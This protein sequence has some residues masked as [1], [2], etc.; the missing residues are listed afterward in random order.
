MKRII[1][2][3]T[4]VATAMITSKAKAQL[5][6][7][8]NRTL[9]DPHSHYSNQNGTYHYQSNPNNNMGTSPN[10]AMYKN[11]SEFYNKDNYNQTLIPTANGVHYT[12][13][14]QG[15]NYSGNNYINVNT[16]GSYNQQDVNG[17]SAPIF[18]NPNQTVNDPNQ[19]GQR[20]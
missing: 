11:Q 17:R 6:T 12:P 18:N 2:A 10:N 1:M 5:W 20:R 16:P 4:I 15:Y 7:T 19:P 3:L 8:D 14:S 9:H 13:G